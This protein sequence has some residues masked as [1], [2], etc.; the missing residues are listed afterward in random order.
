MVPGAGRAGP[1]RRAVA[2]HRGALRSPGGPARL[3]RPGKLPSLRLTHP[4]L[5]CEAWLISRSD[6]NQLDEVQNNCS[7]LLG[8]RGRSSFRLY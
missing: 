5:L 3:P 7:A 2:P 4:P 8:K 1:R 6:F